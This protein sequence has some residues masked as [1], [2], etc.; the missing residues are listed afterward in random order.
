MRHV[1]SRSFLMG[2]ALSLLAPAFAQA[3]VDANTLKTY[4]GQKPR[5]PYMKPSWGNFVINTDR[6][7]R[8][9]SLRQ[10]NPI[11]VNAEGTPT[12]MALTLKNILQKANTHGLNNSD[13]WDEEVERLFQGAL[14]NPKAGVTFEMAASEALIRYATHL[15]TGRVNPSSIDDDIK[16]EKKNFDEYSQLNAAVSYGAAEQTVSSAIEEL[17]PKH[18]IYA[19]LKKVLASL[20]A[21]SKNWQEIK[22]PGFELRRGVTDP[23]I[24]ALRERFNLLGYNVSMSGGKNFDYEFESVVLRYQEQNNLIADGTISVK[25]Q[26]LNS[27]NAPLNQRISQIQIGMEKLRWLPRDLGPRYIFVNTAATEFRMYDE[28]QKVFDFK[29]VNGQPYRRTPTLI[30]KITYVNFNPYWVTPRSIAIKDKLPALKANP[31]YLAEHNMELIDEATDQIV[32]PYT[33]DWKTMTPQRFTYYVRQGPGLGNALGVV[34]F[35][36]QNPYAIYLHDTNERNLFQEKERHRS[37]GCVRLEQPLDLAA[38]LL[39]EDPYWGS[40]Q[41]IDAYVPNIYRSTS[42][43][44][45]YDIK[46]TLKKPVP[47]YLMYITVDFTSDGEIRFLADP[48]G[49]DARVALA[50]QNKK[51]SGE[52]F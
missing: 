39:K 16:V 3:V 45:T 50:L 4:V 21:A 32:D 33:I 20:R 11:W 13:Y 42:Y 38:Y 37:S 44:V 40:R 7:D 28:G 17:A 12:Q 1:V 47:V 48:Y 36:L 29:T 5:I 43:E 25:S 18:P 22:S 9:Y 51:S 23:V 6:L 34:K 14:Q 52:V 41:I 46:V 19:Q 15:S 30:D 26:L 35:P 27:I 31:N 10:Y 49:Q 24:M 8:L 2:V